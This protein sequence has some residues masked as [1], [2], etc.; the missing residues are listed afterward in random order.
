MLTIIRQ[1]EE[2]LQAPRLRPVRERRMKMLLMPEYSFYVEAS[3]C[4]HGGRFCGVSGSCRAH[5]APV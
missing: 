4:R 5:A 2:R 3:V 1:E